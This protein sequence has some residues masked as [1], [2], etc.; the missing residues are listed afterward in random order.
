MVS[1]DTDHANEDQAQ[2]QSHQVLQK[3]KWKHT[4][5]HQKATLATLFG[6][7]EI[8]QVGAVTQGAQLK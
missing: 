8:Q 2:Q 7:Q 3:P 5:T 6:S 4:H 1:I